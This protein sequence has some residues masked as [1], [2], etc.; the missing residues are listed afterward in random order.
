MDVSILE[1]LRTKPQ[2]PLAPCYVVSSRKADKRG[3][4]RA[5]CSSNSEEALSG[6]ELDNRGFVIHVLP[7]ALLCDRTNPGV[8]FA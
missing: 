6:H 5:G 3:T 8:D 4:V 1:N 2:I 7:A